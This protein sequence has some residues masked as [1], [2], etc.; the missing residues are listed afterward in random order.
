MSDQFGGL[1]SKK[2]FG[3]W[4]YQLNTSWFVDYQDTDSCALEENAE[5]SLTFK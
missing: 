3:A 2:C 1:I 5:T 4:V